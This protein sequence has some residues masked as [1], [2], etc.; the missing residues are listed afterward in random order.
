MLIHKSKHLNGRL[1]YCHLGHLKAI[2]RLYLEFA[3]KNNQCADR[4]NTYHYAIIRTGDTLMAE[5]H[6]S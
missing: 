3:F 5:I 6:I 4:L 1:V 2:E